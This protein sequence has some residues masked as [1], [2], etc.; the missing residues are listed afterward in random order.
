[1]KK[2][3]NLF[4]KNKTLIT[5]AL[6]IFLELFFQ[7]LIGVIDS[8]QIS[9]DQDA[10]SAINQTNAVINVINLVF[11]VLGTASI[12]LITQFKGIKDEKNVNKIYCLS[13]YFNLI[14]GIIISFILVFGAKTIFNLM[15]VEERYIDKAIIYMQI[16]GCFSFVIALTTVFSSFLRSNKLMI[17]STIVTGIMNIMNVGGNALAL[18]VFN[19]GIQ[20]VAISSVI[21]RIV[22]LIV[23]VIMYIHYIHSSLSIKNIF[24]F[25]GKLFATLLKIGLPSAG[26]NL[27]YNLS[28][29]VIIMILNYHFILS[30]SID[31]NIRGYIANFTS[32]VYMFSNAIAQSAQVIIGPKIAKN[33]IDDTFHI[34]KDTVKMSGIITV[35]C[36]LIF[37]AISYP[38][39]NSLL[40]I[41][42]PELKS[43]AMNIVLIVCAIDIL[44]EFGRSG[45]IPYVRCLQT[46]GDIYTPVFFAIICCWSVAVLGSYILSA[47]CNLGVIG[48]WISCALDENIRNIIFTFRWNSK[49]WTKFNL[50][51]NIN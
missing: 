18:F 45:N 6:P 24:P 3:L 34:V 5:L 10:V 48:V 38:L 47:F 35:L 33:E 27:S 21:S 13:F 8:I 7:F 50:I 29:L 37:I 19:S 26:E 4:K 46:V 43:Q 1:M 28:Q 44:L 23:I 11:A 39:L 49:K 12:I 2:I 22:G 17:Q 20:G 14:V 36:S 16:N 40:N 25:P 42:D 41:K 31:V 9:F 15:G 51:K 32:I 30:Q